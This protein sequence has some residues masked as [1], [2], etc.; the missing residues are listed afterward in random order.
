MPKQVNKEM[1]NEIQQKMDTSPSGGTSNC[2]SLVWTFLG[3][4]KN[5]KPEKQD[6]WAKFN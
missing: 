1:L 4:L 3:S 2:E 5:L 6:L